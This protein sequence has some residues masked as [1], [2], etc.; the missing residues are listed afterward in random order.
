MAIL[1]L[2]KPSATRDSLAL[3]FLTT[4]FVFTWFD[5]APLPFVS[6][7]VG[8]G[9]LAAAI[10]LLLWQRRAILFG[11][12]FF[13]D[14]IRLARR[15]RYAVL[16]TLYALSILLA[17]LYIFMTLD[18]YLTPKDILFQ[19]LLFTPYCTMA[20]LVLFIVFSSDFK[21]LAEPLHERL[22]L[23]RIG[24]QHVLNDRAVELLARRILKGQPCMNERLVQVCGAVRSV[25]LCLGFLAVGFH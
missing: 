4:A 25:M 6:P 11:P 2:A 21:Y 16:R 24:L 9:V 3:L 19:R 17:L 15:G 12:V 13:Y 18:I 5:Y 10:L 20:L 14:V 23:W 8:A 22:R 1:A 7:R